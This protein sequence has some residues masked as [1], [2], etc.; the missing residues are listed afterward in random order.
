MESVN[1]TAVSLTPYSV[2]AKWSVSVSAG[3]SRN[4][5]LLRKANSPIAQ[6]TITPDKWTAD[7]ES[8]ALMIANETT[9]PTIGNIEVKVD[10]DSL[11][12]VAVWEFDTAVAYSAG[13]LVYYKAAANDVK[14]YRANKVHNGAWD[15]ADFDAIS[16][17]IKEEFSASNNYVIWDIVYYSNK[18]YR[19]IKA[20]NAA[21]W[22]AADFEELLIVAADNLLEE[23]DSDWVT[24]EVVLKNKTT[25]IVTLNVIDV[26]GKNPNRVFT[27]RFANA[28]V[29]I[30]SQED[31]GGTTKLTI[32][33]EKADTS[34]TV[35]DLI[36]SIDGGTSPLCEAAT[37]TYSIAGELSNGDTIEIA[38]TGNVVKLIDNISYKV[39]ADAN[40][41]NILKSDFNDYFKVGDS[42]AKVFASNS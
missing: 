39:S 33:V 31:L 32:A 28:L 4:T 35:A 14:L 9:V 6:F 8:L 27:K 24:V 36:V 7:L 38:A 18:L 16:L 22:D 17:T 40:R 2:V 20:H 13:D 19:A 21:A 26:N 1:W 5:V 29:Y 10:G 3:S 42:Y 25:W 11:N 30:A 15:A 23:I 37:C 41:T 34:Y 12:L